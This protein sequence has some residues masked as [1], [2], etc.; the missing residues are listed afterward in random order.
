MLVQSA[1]F[2][3]SASHSLTTQ[4]SE[5]IQIE[6]FGRI[7]GRR[8]PAEHNARVNTPA[9][10]PGALQRSDHPHATR[11]LETA[12]DESSELEPRLKLLKQLIEAL[13]GRLLQSFDA[14]DLQMAENGAEIAPGSGAL[15]APD[16]ATAPAPGGMRI[17]TL[18]EYAEQESLS[19]RAQGRIE[20]ADGQRI[21]FA[22]ELQMQRSFVERSQSEISWG[23][24]PR[25]KD[26]LVINFD[27]K[28]AQLSAERYAFD[29]NADGKDEMIP[30]LAPGRAFL[31]LDRN[32]NGRVDDGS[33]LLGALSGQAYAD[34]AKLD[35][36]GN[37]FVDG[38]DLSFA[39]LGLW[40]PGTLENRF[41]SMEEHGIA[42]LASSNIASDFK[43]TDPDGKQTGQLRASS[44][45]VTDA[46]QVGT[47]QQLD[48]VI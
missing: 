5:H 38:G 14:A 27:G 42:A 40:R 1:H 29:L 19:F 32:G 25:L 3:L 20:T 39:Q 24:V 21:E 10:P 47:T 28:A 36:D 31:V 45:F 46:G 48:L 18:H 4:R 43:L 30:G 12:A 26:P 7:D 22:V 23:A 11:E 6:T 41:D 35:A 16:A 13:T 44:I 9:T 2:G 34:L 37:G 8:Q 15:A 17:R 33:E